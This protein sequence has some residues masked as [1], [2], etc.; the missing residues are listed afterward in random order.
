[1][2]V[3]NRDRIERALTLLST[4][5][6][7][8]IENALSDR[9]PAGKDWALV[10]A[11]KDAGN[12]TSRAYDRTDVQNQL[13]VLTESLA[14]GWLPF[15]NHLSRAE[16]SLASELREVRNQWAHQKPFSADDTY[17]A[18]DTAERL[19][20]ATNA[21]AQA[22][23]VRATR[24]DLQRREFETEVARTTRAR[25]S[26]PG[27]EAQGLPAWSDVL[28]PHPDIAAGR[29][30]ASEFAAD[31][32]EVAEGRGDAEYSDP[33]EFFRRTFLTEG[34]GQLLAR[35]TARIAGDTA[36][37][38]VIN[39]QTNFGGGKTHSMLA[40]WHLVSGHPAGDYPQ[41]IQELLAG[42][43]ISGWDKT[44]RR[45]ALVGNEIPTG[46]PMS[47]SDGTQVNT[48][49]GELAWQLGGR[50]AYNLL[51]QADATASNPGALLKGLLARYSPC[52]ILIDEWVAYARGLYARRPVRRNVRDPIH[53]CPDA[54]RSRLGDPGCAAARIGAS[55][56]RPAGGRRSRRLGS[57]NWRRARA[58][59][60]GPVAKRRRPDII[61]VA[62]C[63]LAGVF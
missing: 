14:P 15:D 44:V 62:A 47:K 63:I 50:Q 13:R 27:L 49:W 26:L 22:D 30:A 23:E 33:V 41:E 24:V 16:K 7:P 2:A 51:A 36:A 9:V 43:D 40:V 25:T 1:M 19:L 61:R 52:V 32:H 60:I 5:L 55:L 54:H 58:A 59:S 29:Y 6:D 21:V 3:S 39:L 4:G 56:R 46:Q 57:R 34:L 31:L 8:F 37:D 48:L 45:V 53:F 18:L 17:R 35:A 42:I 38:P 28:T 20:R 11:A 12:G 10:L